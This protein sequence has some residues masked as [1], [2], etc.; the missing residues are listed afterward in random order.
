ML[1]LYRFLLWLY[2]SS[3][4]REYGDEMTA[5][6]REAQAEIEKKGVVT[7]GRFWFREVGGLVR[8]AMEEYA[9]SVAGP[10]SWVLFPTRRFTMHSE[11]RFPRATAFLM[12][13][14]LAGTVLAIEKATAIRASVRDVNPPHVGPI[15]PEHFTF[16]P[17]IALM[18]A[19]A[20]AVGL[21]GWAILFALKR[22]G[23]HRLSGMQNPAGHE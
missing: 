8:G 22:S 17:T 16:M 14:I 12:T 13:V 19:G 15:Q 9:R 1:A 6:F 5:V 11:F 10:H 21:I 20:Y 2:P 7:R 4:R 18:L 23:V 3:H